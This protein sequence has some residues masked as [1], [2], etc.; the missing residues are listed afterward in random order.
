MVNHYEFQAHWLSFGMRGEP[1]THPILRRQDI[2]N[3]NDFQAYIMSFIRN[4]PPTPNLKATEH[5]QPLRV[6]STSVVIW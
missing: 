3:H 4:A 1:S 2:I 6:P 5:G